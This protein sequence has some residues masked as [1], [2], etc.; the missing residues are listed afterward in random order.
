MSVHMHLPRGPHTDFQGN[1][2]ATQR[3]PHLVPWCFGEFFARQLG[4]HCFVFV[5][6][7]CYMPLLLACCQPATF[8][9]SPTTDPKGLFETNTDTGVCW[10][11]AI[12]IP[13]SFPSTQICAMRASSCTKIWRQGTLSLNVRRT[14]RSSSDRGPP[15]SLI[16]VNTLTRVIFGIRGAE[17]CMT[18]SFQGHFLGRFE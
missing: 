1:K 3:V 8:C 2:H 13:S 5:M 15:A 7:G 17:W 14:T 11:S 4:W 6:P 18:I 10:S 9:H 12:F 16:L